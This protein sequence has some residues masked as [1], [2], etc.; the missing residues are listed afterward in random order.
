MSSPSS[1]SPHNPFPDPNQANDKDNPKPESAPQS[2]QPVPVVYRTMG[3]PARPD[4]AK[5]E[6]MKREREAQA[7]R[8]AQDK[9]QDGAGSGMEGKVAVMFIL[10]FLGGYMFM[11]YALKSRPEDRP[12]QSWLKE[13]DRRVTNKSKPTPPPV[14]TPA[15]TP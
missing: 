13:L 2:Q 5:I 1:G 11:I 4:P 9:G 12:V 10:I 3:L 8:A 6:E 7:A 14:V 15:A